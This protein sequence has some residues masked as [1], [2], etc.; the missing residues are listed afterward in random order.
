M[1]EQTTTGPP[2]PK[3]PPF[4]K[5]PAPAP[6]L[7]GQQEKLNAMAARIR[8]SEERYSELRKKM[9]FVEQNMLSNH[10]RAMEEIKGLHD[11]I[12]GMKRAI[13]AI[14]DRIITI[15]KELRLTARKE[16]IDVVKRYVELWDPTRFVTREHVEKLIDKKLNTHEDHKPPNYDS[17]RER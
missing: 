6:D 8:V 7:G 2:A 16:D 10:K 12:T 1:A 4:S 15:V 14:E 9:L 5:P 13:Q 17:P 3:K 11:D